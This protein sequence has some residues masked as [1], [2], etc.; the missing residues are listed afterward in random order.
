MADEENKLKKVPKG[1]KIIEVKPAEMPKP[2]QDPKI[3]YNMPTWKNPDDKSVKMPKPERK[4][5]IIVPK[6][7]S[8]IK[9]FKGGGKAIK[10]LGRAFQ[11]GGKV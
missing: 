9:Q 7:S 5:Y 3:K 4:S 8:K 6:D 2:Y 11:K 10:G 1:Y